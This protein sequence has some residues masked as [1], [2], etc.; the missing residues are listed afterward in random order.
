MEQRNCITKKRK[1]KH[2]NEGERYKIEVLLQ[3]KR[4]IKEIAVI[5]SRNRS[6]IYRELKRGTISRLQSNLS[7]KKQYRAN[8]GQLNYVKQGKNKER[9]LKIGKDRRLEEYIR[10]K[11]IKDKFSPDAIIGQIKEKRLKFKGLIC[12]K[13]LYNYID[14][15]I[16]SGLSNDNLWEKR[17]RKKRRYKTVSRVSC[18]NR[19]S[20]SI[21]DRAEEV[22]NRIEYG[23]WEG[24]CVK[25][26]LG[27]RLK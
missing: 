26:P 24:D 5:L 17:K 19:M 6:T 21:E 27:T 22:N 4:K 20:R 1:Y 2:L 9:R 23:H 11:I 15:G 12:T 8:V 3:E 18:K 13:T 25:G 16:F 7:E 14:A 10:E